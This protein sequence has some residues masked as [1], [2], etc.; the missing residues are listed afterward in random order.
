MDENQIKYNTHNVPCAKEVWE[1]A[2]QFALDSK[3]TEWP[4]TREL[5]ATPKG[6]KAL[7]EDLA[8]DSVKNGQIALKSVMVA[9]TR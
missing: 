6:G 2:R 3:T 9:A 8:A 7:L 4:R 5:P 1:G